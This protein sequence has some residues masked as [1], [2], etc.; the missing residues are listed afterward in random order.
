MPVEPLSLVAGINKAGLSLL[1][2]AGRRYSSVKMGGA[3]D[4]PGLVKQSG[5]LGEFIKVDSRGGYFFQDDLVRGL[6]AYMH[7]EEI[8]EK[9]VAKERKTNRVAVLEKVGLYIRVMLNHLRRLKREVSNGRQLKDDAESLIAV[10]DMID[11]CD[12]PTKP[13]Q[14]RTTICPLPAFQ[15]NS[16]GSIGGQDSDGEDNANGGPEL[17]CTY[18]DGELLE[19]VQLYSDSSL[20]EATWY[21]EGETGCILACFD[22]GATLQLEVANC[23]LV[24][25]K[26][27]QTALLPP[28]MPRKRE[29][30]KKRRKKK[31]LSYF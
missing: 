27:N 18:W 16:S 10:L 31:V 11:K 12:T 17:V 22:E 4:V 8:F 20:V 3:V 5:M 1:E 15:T 23:C 25:G 21:E 28:D 13:K 9:A 30:K 29:K 6:M 7:E 14:E 24:G 2:I 26:I 19:A